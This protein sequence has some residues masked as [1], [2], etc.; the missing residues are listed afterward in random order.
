MFCSVSCVH[1]F[2]SSFQ[3]VSRLCIPQTSLSLV[4]RIEQHQ[5]DLDTISVLF[6]SRPMDESARLPPCLIFTMTTLA[7]CL[8]NIPPP[9]VVGCLLVAFHNGEQDGTGR[10]ERRIE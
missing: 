9:L 8:G 6:L 7:D 1:L 10:I 4:G 3:D 2:I 5:H